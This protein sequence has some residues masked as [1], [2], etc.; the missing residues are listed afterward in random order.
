MGGLIL[1]LDQGTTS[2][3]ALLFDDQ[4]NLLAMAQEEFAQI[5][6]HPGWVEHD[7][8]A[9]LETSL[10][11][12][13][14][15]LEKAGVAAS[16]LAAIGVTNQRETVVL[17]DRQTGRPLYHAL[18][19]Q[20]RRTSELCQKLASEG[21]GPLIAEKTGLV[22][23]PYFSATKL[24]WLLDEVPGARAAAERG[25][26]CFGTIECWLI[27]H[28]TGGHS[29]KTDATNASRTML[30]NIVDGQW[31]ED[32]LAL[33]DV[34]PALLPEVVDC[35][36]DFGVTA[37]SV[38]GAQVPIRGAAGDQQA[39]LIG[40]ACFEPG[41]MKATYGTGC[42]AVLNI[43]AEPVVSSSNL[44]TTLAYQLDGKRT[45]ALEGSIFIAGAAVQW[46]RDEVG[47]IEAARECDQLAASSNLDD[48]VCLVPA[49]T[50]LGAPYWRAN[51]RG[52]LMNLTRGTGRA[53]IV[54]A[55]LESVGLQTY[56]LYQ[57]M[58]KDWPDLAK[59][60]RVLRVDGGMSASEWTMQFVADMLDCPIDRPQLAETTA[61]G[62]AYLAGRGAGLC[63]DLG[64]FAH[65]WAVDKR[66][67]P[68][69]TAAERACKV[70]R[71]GLAVAGVLAAEG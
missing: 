44:L 21:H 62:A 38:L 34:P 2:S 31:D 57:A 25:A 9:I 51:A 26:L 59:T 36:G 29:H 61:L 56:D 23:D 50:G 1:S 54:R 66:F 58:M 69:L 39:A 43:G 70:E 55:T 64:E 16:E 32:L 14:R 37:A 33:F 63:P 53:E 19:W 41:Q 10:A 30:Y 48:P 27:W 49:F 71:W 47:L 6:P 4:L 13:R 8:D 40:Q 15:V 28:L 42:F 52:A 11:C 20:D 17:W 5:Y 45:Y 24:K 68:V 3:R 18:V 65:D 60:D 12:A 35:D 46:L 67:E 22:L 7:A